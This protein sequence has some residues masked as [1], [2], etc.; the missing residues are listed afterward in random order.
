MLK[1]KALELRG[2]ERG[3][4]QFS[5]TSP[6]FQQ[7]E[8]M[9]L[10]YS[11]ATSKKGVEASLILLPDHIEDSASF[12]AWLP[13]VKGKIVLMSPYF[14]DGRPL[15]SWKEHATKETYHTR[16]LQTRVKKSL[17]KISVVR[18]YALYLAPAL[19]KAGFVISDVYW[20]NFS[21]Q[22]YTC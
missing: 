1:I 7:L 13:S 2:W 12:A 22:K 9:Q 11:P 5:M 14:A 15:Y 16:S 8:G 3:L 20:Q 4:D 21:K 19:E 18:I 17:M 10:A 6:R